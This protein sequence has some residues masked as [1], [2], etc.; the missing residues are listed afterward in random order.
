MHATNGRSDIVAK[1]GS[2]DPAG[3]E[4]PLR[5]GRQ[6]DGISAAEKGILLAGLR[7]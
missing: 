4:D 2:P 1:R 6:I 3:V 5:Q 7:P